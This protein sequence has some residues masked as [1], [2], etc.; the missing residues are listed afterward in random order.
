M[1]KL[2]NSRTSSKH[3]FQKKATQY[4]HI[5]VSKLWRVY[6]FD[7]FSRLFLKNHHLFICKYR[8]NLRHNAYYTFIGLFFLQRTQS[9]EYTIAYCTQYLKSFQPWPIYLSSHW[10]CQLKKKSYKKRL[11]LVTFIKLISYLENFFIYFEHGVIKKLVFLRAN[12]KWKKFNNQARFRFF[13]SVA[14]SLNQH[15]ATERFVRGFFSICATL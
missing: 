6:K 14:I 5:F 3:N 12:I 1:L 8:L 4:N 9:Y 15:D 7:T 11:L 13:S 2:H 10:A